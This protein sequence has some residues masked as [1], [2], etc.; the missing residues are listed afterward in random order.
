MGTLGAALCAALVA[1]LL[2]TF[3][4][5]GVKAM[6]Q[7]KAEQHRAEVARVETQ[8][9]KAM[10][11]IQAAPKKC[12]LMSRSSWRPRNCRICSIT[13]RPIPTRAAKRA[14]E[15]LKQ[16]EAIKQKIKDEKNSPTPRRDFEISRTCHAAV[17]R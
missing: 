8:L 4:L 17:S 9:K 2:P 16:I 1:W 10:V 5:F 3:D 13:R 7:A 14:E 15:T 11:A 6:Q 12:R